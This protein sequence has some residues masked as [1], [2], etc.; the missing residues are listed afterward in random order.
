MSKESLIPDQNR[1][2]PYSALRELSRERFYTLWQLAKAGE[3]LEGDDA[4]LAQAMREHPEYYDTWAHANELLGEAIPADSV[5]PFLHVIMHTIIEHQAAQNDPP[6][7]RAAL[8]FKTARNVP[9]HQAVHEIAY[10]FSQF[11]WG[12]LHDHKKFDNTAYR[13]KLAKLLPRAQRNFPK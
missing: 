8:E 7:V 10:I 13:R 5:N 11:L 9:R 2:D 3:E 12:V 6:E 1:T 4:R